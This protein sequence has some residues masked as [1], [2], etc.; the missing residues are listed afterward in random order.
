M[1]HSRKNIINVT[2]SGQN[3]NSRGCNSIAFINMGQ[4]GLWINGILPIPPG[5][6]IS[7]SEELPEMK[8]MTEYYIQFDESGAPPPAFTGDYVNAGNSCIVII[9]HTSK[10]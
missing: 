1:Y 4:T 2:K 9:K 8:D 10:V 5:A 3:I 6:S 7:M